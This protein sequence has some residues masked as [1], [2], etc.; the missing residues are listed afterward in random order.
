MKTDKSDLDDN[1][2]CEREGP[3]ERRDL[4]LII[5]VALVALGSTTPVAEVATTAAKSAR[6]YV[7]VTGRVH[8]A[9]LP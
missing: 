1:H 8:T 2:V 6:F 7:R 5:P 3:L 4:L 9:E